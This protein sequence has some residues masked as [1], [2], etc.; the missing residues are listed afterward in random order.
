[1]AKYK[2]TLLPNDDEGRRVTFDLLDKINGVSSDLDTLNNYW[3]EEFKKIGGEVKYKS[4]SGTFNDTPGATATIT[5]NFNKG[6][7]YFVTIT[8]SVQT[9]GTLG[10]VS[11]INKTATTFDVIKTGSATGITFDYLIALQ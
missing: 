4:G 6:D 5:H 11:V 8:P 7:D 3:E 1:M 2:S 9:S 10:E